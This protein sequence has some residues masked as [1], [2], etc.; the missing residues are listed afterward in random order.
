MERFETQSHS[1]V[2]RLWLEETIEADGQATLRGHVSNVSNGRQGYVQ[3]V[4][5]IVLF[6][7]PYLES[8]G[9]QLSWSLRIKRWL[10]KQKRR[11]ID[12]V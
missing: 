3:S 7:A 1:F 5:D 8:M 12:L 10:R 9:I 2:I 11:L 6:M 4:E